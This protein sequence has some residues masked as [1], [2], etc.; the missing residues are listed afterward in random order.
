MARTPSRK[1]SSNA[2]AQ[3]VN[4]SE[5]VHGLSLG[6]TYAE[7]EGR[8]QNGD[9]YEIVEDRT[10]E[11]LQHRIRSRGIV[12]DIIAEKDSRLLT[13]D[14]IGR[15]EQSVASSST[16]AI[17]TA[18]GTYRMRKAALQLKRTPRLWKGKTVVFFGA[19]N[20]LY[21]TIGMKEGAGPPDAP[22]NLGAAVAWS[23]T[24]PPGVYVAM[25]GRVYSPERVRKH[26]KDGLFDILTDKEAD[27]FSDEDEWYDPA[28]ELTLEDLKRLNGIEITISIPEV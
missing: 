23:L 12:W 15:Y 4:R 26:Q 6:G 11:Y 20:P 21:S 24:L 13:A 14:D 19:F 2:A 18:I 27:D 17:V 22:F 16:K 25:H 10:P 9:R 3:V 5:L 8:R 1:G 7:I 28:K